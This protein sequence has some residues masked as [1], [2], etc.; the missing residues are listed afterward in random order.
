MQCKEFKDL[1]DSYLKD[2]LLIETNHDVIQHLEACHA[3]RR[4]LAARRETRAQLRRAFAVAPDLQM[5]P[6]FAFK[7]RNELKARALGK[8]KHSFNLSAFFLRP[9]WLALAACLAIAILV[10]IIALN[11]Q[12][13]GAGTNQIARTDA[14]PRL[15]AASPAPNGHDGRELSGA[16]VQL[17]N[18]EVTEARAVGD[19]QNCAIKYNLPE[20]PI[21]LEEAG[22]KYDAAY[23]NLAQAVQ[24][25]GGALAGQIK[26][27]EDHSCIYQGQRFAH[28]ILEYKH[29]RVSLLVAETNGDNANG[30][31]VSR[32]QV[33]GY[34]VSSFETKKH[35]IFVVSDLPEA[36]NMAI[37]RELAPGVSA[38][39][40]R[41]EA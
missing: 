41:T 8:P 24:S 9:Q 15:K 22:R 7:M 2:E 27:I 37:A 13:S 34:Q 28:V 36:D 3:C 38:H 11:H 19:H 40:A 20:E 18:F 26:Y 17:A 1:V 12:R 10:G 25:D 35:S 30:H 29:A 23:S 14:E 31:P 39:I 5:R 33:N 6:E 32:P 21:P 16:A 4:E